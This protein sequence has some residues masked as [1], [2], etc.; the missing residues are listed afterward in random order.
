M[1]EGLVEAKGR[2]RRAEEYRDG[3]RSESVGV[4]RRGKALAAQASATDAELFQRLEAQA[5]AAILRER[6]NDA[7]VSAYIPHVQVAPRSASRVC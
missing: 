6:F 3:L 5:D 4:S 7:D 2:S 1:H